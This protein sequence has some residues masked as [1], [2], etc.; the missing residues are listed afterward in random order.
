MREIEGNVEGK[1]YRDVPV[2]GFIRHIPDSPWYLI[3]KID[4]DEVLRPLQQL[5]RMIFLV[6]I[7]SIFIAGITILYFIEVKRRQTETRKYQIELEHQ[8]LVKHYDYLS[9]YANDAI[10]LLNDKFEILEMNDRVIDYYGYTREELVNRP[11]IQ[12]RPV[13]LRLKLDEILEKIEG[14]EG[15]VYETNHQHKDGTIFPIEASLR[16][17]EIDE[18]IYY[19]SIVR[20]ITKR[21]L[22]EDALKES[23]ELFRHTFEQVA[24]GM[25]ILS[26]DGAWLQVNQ[27]LCDI[28]GYT[29]DELMK[30]SYTEITHPEHKDQDEER[31]RQMVTGLRS[32]ESWEK[33]YIRKDGTLI[34][35]RITTSLIRTADGRPNYF[36]T[37]TEDITG[38]KRIEED[39]RESESRYRFLFEHNPA[40]MLIYERGTLKM[41]AVNEAFQKHYGYSMD[42]ALAMLLTDLYPEEEKKPIT[43]ITSQLHGYH[44]VGEWHHRKRDGSYTTILA[45]SHDLD[46]KGHTARVAVMTDITDRKYAEQIIKNINLELE[47]RVIQ[48]TAQL[49]A[50]NKELEAF[51]Y[52]V[53]HDLRAPLRAIDGFTQILLEEYVGKLDPEGQRLF[54]VISYNA[55]KMG[56][57]ISDLLEFSRAGRKELLLTSVNLNQIFKEVFTELTQN[58]SGRSIKLNLKRLPEVKGDAGLLKIMITNLLSNAIKFTRKRDSARI[59]VS[60]QPEADRYIFSVKDNGVGFDMRYVNKLFGVFQRLHTEQE[61]VGTGVGLALV[62]RIVHRHNGQTWAEATVDRGAT[63]YF[64]LPVTD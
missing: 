54:N 29:R 32:S 43:E 59:T 57:L 41:L 17:I 40:P 39:L 63:F 50:A 26:P 52:S 55:R 27:R 4:R 7:L 19:Q 10:F 62:Q 47:Q 5:Q 31:I 46:Y 33:R 21:R 44:N 11:I 18:Q 36:I 37:I 1:D 9:K 20:D 61:F 23:E 38:P 8:V 60:C 2:L 34:W 3:A 35:A 51:S 13:E 49:E 56:Q 16:K 22:V 24:V 45:C 14:K 15:V 30:L 42:E 58:E 64:S 48:R 12:L 25:S 53:S 28:L 6:I